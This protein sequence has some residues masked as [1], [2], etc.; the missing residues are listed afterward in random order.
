MDL[1]PK[2]DGKRKTQYC[3]ESDR[4]QF[5]DYVDG[6]VEMALDGTIRT[7]ERELIEVYGKSHEHEEAP[8]PESVHSVLDRW[9]QFLEPPTD[10]WPVFPTGHY[11]SKRDALVES[12]GEEQVS[13]ALEG[14]GDMGK[15]EVLNRP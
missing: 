12:I 10:D 7:V 4:K 13:E 2:D 14:R 15:T 1:L 11:G 3:S 9:Y 5:I 6:C 8:F